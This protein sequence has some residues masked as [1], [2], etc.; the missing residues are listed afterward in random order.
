M[1]HYLRHGFQVS[2][3]KLGTGWCCDISGRVEAL[4]IKLLSMQSRNMIPQESLPGAKG[5]CVPVRAPSSLLRGSKT[6][7][8]NSIQ[9]E[10]REK[11]W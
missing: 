8:S 3:D 11:A 9:V 1:A 2:D 6:V 10:A 4:W 7:D 5:S